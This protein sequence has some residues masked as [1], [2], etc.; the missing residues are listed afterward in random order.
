MPIFIN[1][2]FKQ[3]ASIGAL[4]ALTG[5]SALDRLSAIGEQ[6]SLSP[7][8]N[9]VQRP[10]YIPITLPMPEAM[11]NVREP[12]SL[13]RSGSRSFFKDQR[14]SR[15]G[16]LLTVVIDIDNKAELQNKTSRERNNTDTA[17]ASSLLGLEAELGKV[18]PDAIDPTSLLDTASK[19]KNEGT[20]KINRDEKIKVNVAAIVTQVLPNGNLVISGRQEISVNFELREIKVAGIVRPED[21]NSTNTISSEKIAE[22]RIAYGGRGQLTDVQQPRY[23]S[24]VLDILMPF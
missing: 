5:C 20:G 2:S 1:R 12:N 15:V 17:S 9:P 19:L 24:Q 16:D 11:T 10:G 13:W 6:P 22:A 21:I 23:G 8:E 3:I 4:L 7:I 14:A 18:L